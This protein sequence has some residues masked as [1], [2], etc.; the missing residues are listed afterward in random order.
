M[1]RR[2][3]SRVPSPQ[4]LPA[5][6]GARRALDFGR[7]ALP[8]APAP[9]SALHWRGLVTKRSWRGEYSRLLELSDAGVSTFDA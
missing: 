8:P 4:T 6:R 7:P 5:A 9:P 3:R 2:S 1:K